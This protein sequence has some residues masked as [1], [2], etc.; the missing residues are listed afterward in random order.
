[1][2]FGADVA[3]AEEEAQM[4]WLVGMA[5]GDGTSR[6]V[7]CGTDAVL[8]TEAQREELQITSVALGIGS[9]TGNESHGY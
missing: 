6:T 7:D 5:E 1:L 3:R 8:Q 9:M 2:A 4:T